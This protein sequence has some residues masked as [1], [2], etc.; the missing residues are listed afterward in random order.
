MIQR[1]MVALELWNYVEEVR[2]PFML[3]IGSESTIVDE[4]Q[5]QRFRQIV[6]DISMVTV[7]DA[8]HVIVHDKLDEF[9]STVRSFLKTH[10]L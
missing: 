6:P 7:Q 3:L 10:S 9:E 4:D 5:Q 8:G 2:A 1:G